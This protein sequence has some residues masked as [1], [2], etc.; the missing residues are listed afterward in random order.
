MEYNSR[1]QTGSFDEEYRGKNL[2]P[3]SLGIRQI[4][5]KDLRRVGVCT[6]LWVIQKGLRSVPY[7][8]SSQS[9]SFIWHLKMVKGIGTYWRW[10][11]EK[12]SS[13]VLHPDRENGQHPAKNAISVTRKECMHRCWIKPHCSCLCVVWIYEWMNELMNS[14]VSVR[15]RHSLYPSQVFTSA[16]IKRDC[17]TRLYLPIRSMAVSWTTPNSRINAHFAS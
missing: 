3:P 13:A 6:N 8:M 16:Q 4:L 10:E 11:S 7:P 1:D 15:N 17:L 12:L 5:W 9:I 14:F 2:V